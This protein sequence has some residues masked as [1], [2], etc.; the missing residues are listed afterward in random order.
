MAI[1]KPIKSTKVVAPKA[2]VKAPPVATRERLDVSPIMGVRQYL[3][4]IGTRAH[5]IESMA[6]WAKAKGFSVATVA[7]WKNLFESY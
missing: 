1:K 4:S 7:Q 6:V 5:K 3:M 2:E